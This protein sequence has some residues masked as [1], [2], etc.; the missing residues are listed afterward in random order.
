[1]SV[2]DF[3]FSLALISVAAGML[4]SLVGLG[5]G[6]I[7]VPVLTLVYHV[8]IR[9]A[10]GASILSVIATSSGAAVAYVREKLTNLRAGMFLEIAT[11]IGALTGA[12]ITTLISGNGLY[13]LF[14]LVLI[15]SALA[16]SRNRRERAVLSSSN[17][18]LANYF[19]LHGSYYDQNKHQTI[20]YKVAG[21]KVGLALM[22]IAGMISALL[23][24]GSGALKVP[25]M[26]IAMHMPIKA[27]AATSDFMIGVTA[28][29]SAGAY[30]ARG[31]INPVIAAPIAIGVLIGSVMGSRLLNK[32]APRYVKV[33]FIIVLVIVAAEMLQR[34]L[35]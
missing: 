35:S 31:Q 3:V 8:D 21:T 29:A 28:A 15:Y 23:G 19:N 12:Y 4:G 26:D 17:D 13:I 2:T 33:L 14:A 5:G 6:V 22:Y 7:I 1:M 34:G 25:A 18:R 27:S 10:I 30:F 24:V 16:M 32:V 9:L 11:T 20:T